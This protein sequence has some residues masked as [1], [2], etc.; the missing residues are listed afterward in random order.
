MAAC[1]SRRARQPASSSPTP[2]SSPS[3]FFFRNVSDATDVGLGAAALVLAGVCGGGGTAA[4][5]RDAIF[6][7]ADDGAV[8]VGAARVVQDETA[9]VEVVGGVGAEL[10]F[11]LA[12]L[13]L[14]VTSTLFSFFFALS[15]PS[16]SASTAYLA[17]ALAC[18][19]ARRACLLPM[20]V[21]VN[22]ALHYRDV[23]DVMAPVSPLG[24][25]L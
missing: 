25:F 21:R 1:C 7:V 6:A 22:V 20:R 24:I 13:F 16:G 12:L 2:S 4:A 19:L 15:A 3:I 17:A 23:N 10:L 11:N 9:A 8:A 5:A 18:S 14:F